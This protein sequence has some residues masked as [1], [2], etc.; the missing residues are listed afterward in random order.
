MYSLIFW[1]CVISGASPL[2]IIM[3]FFMGFFM[4]YDA[5]LVLYV[6]FYKIKDRMDYVSVDHHVYY[7]T[8]YKKPRVKAEKK[9]VKIN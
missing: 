2:Y 9:T 8:L 6:L 5:T 7:L 3:L 4:A 1:L